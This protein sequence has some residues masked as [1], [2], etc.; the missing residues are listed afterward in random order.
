MYE[1]QS[2]LVSNVHTVVGLL[3]SA[4]SNVDLE[5][6]KDQK[7]EK[8]TAINNYLCNRG[9]VAEYSPTCDEVNVLKG[10][11]HRDL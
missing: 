10:N 8:K 3:L 1:Q 7:L 4:Q 5:L 11:I 6:Q 9:I 2:L